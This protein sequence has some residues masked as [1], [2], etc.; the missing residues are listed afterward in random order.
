MLI[1]NLVR[2][3]APRL[4]LHLVSEGPTPGTTYLVQPLRCTTIAPGTFYVIGSTA[5]NATISSFC[6]G[7]ELLGDGATDL[8]QNGTS[9]SAGDGVVLIRRV[10]FASVPQDQL[11][12]WGPVTGWGEGSP[13]TADRN[14]AESLQRRPADADTDDNLTDFLRL[15]P[16]PCAPPP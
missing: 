13:A 14:S 3:P 5:L 9:A 11:S 6:P 8:L 4:E 2:S 15:A 16:T 12:Y 10:I 1:D 7:Y